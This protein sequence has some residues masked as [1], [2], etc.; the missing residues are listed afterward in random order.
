[1]LLGTDDLRVPPGPNGRAYVTALKL[2]IA[3]HGDPERVK[4]Q[5]VISLEYEG[6][7]HALRDKEENLHKINLAIF[8]FML[9]RLPADN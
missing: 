1:M 5:K 8:D 6:E 2:A 7:G 3:K 4:R 9:K